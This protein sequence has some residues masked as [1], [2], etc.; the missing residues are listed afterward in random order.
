MTDLIDIPDIAEGIQR[1]AEHCE[2]NGA[3]VTGRVVRAQLAL[4][5][6]GTKCGERLRTWPGKPLEDA[7]PLRLTGGFHHLVL[8]GA[9]DR[10]LPVYAGKITDQAGVDAIVTAIAA[11]HDAALLPWFDSPPQTNEAGRSASFMAGLKWL[12]GKLGARFEMNELGAS[13]GHQHDDGPL[14]L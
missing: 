4:M 1:Q 2:Q 9:D 8:T 10:L 6:G 5:H 11:D 12:S 3:F 13:R 7:L 14:P